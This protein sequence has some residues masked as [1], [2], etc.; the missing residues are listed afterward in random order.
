MDF[1]AL[2]TRVS[3]LPALMERLEN[4][5]PRLEAF[6]DEHAPVSVSED[7]LASSDDP[8]GEEQSAVAEPQMAEPLVSKDPPAEQVETAAPD[9]DAPASED[10]AS[11]PSA[12]EAEAPTPA[13]A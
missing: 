4:V 13:Q 7:G 11:P 6:L 8:P 10:P 2:M 1:D 12:S 5:L 3:G 9:G